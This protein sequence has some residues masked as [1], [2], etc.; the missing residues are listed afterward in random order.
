MTSITKKILLISL[1]LMLNA[2]AYDV[3]HYIPV[4]YGVNT[5]PAPRHGGNYQQ[6]YYNKQPNTYYSNNRD[7]HEH[8]DNGKHKG[9]HKNKH[10]DD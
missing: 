9:Q 3:Q 10:H 8:H 5:S 4:P 6:L 2:C 1:P 7:Y